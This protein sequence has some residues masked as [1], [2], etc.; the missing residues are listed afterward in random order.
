MKTLNL[1]GISLLIVLAVLFSGCSSI[2]EGVVNGS[3]SITGYVHGANVSS[4]K[5]EI[6]KDDDRQSWRTLGIFPLNSTTEDSVRGSILANWNTSQV[7]DGRYVV[8]VTAIDSNGLNSSDYVYLTV[9]NKAEKAACPV[10]TCSDLLEGDNK[11][12]VNLTKEQYGNNMNCTVRCSCGQ[13]LYALV[14]SNGNLEP[15]YYDYVDFGGIPKDS[16]GPNGGYN[17][18]YEYP[19]NWSARYPMGF[20]KDESIDIKLWTD[21]SNGGSAGYAGF[22]VSKI[23]CSPYCVSVP[24]ETKEYIAK[25]RLNNATSVTGNGTYS[26][27][28]ETSFSDLSAGQNYTL[29]VDVRSTAG[30]DLSGYVAAWID[31]DGNQDLATE[32]DNPDYDWDK[33][34][35]N[36][37]AT[38]PSPEYIDLG[39]QTLNK[40]VYTYS[41]TFSVPENASTGKARMRISLKEYDSTIGCLGTKES[42]AVYYNVISPESC[43][44]GMSG[45]VEDY[46]VNIK[47]GTCNLA[48]DEPPCGE[49]AVSEVVSLIGRWSAGDASLEDVLGLITAWSK[50]G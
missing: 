17:E 13:G 24:S 28:T 18:F 38:I 46:T 47:Q 7:S 23:I 10:W 29:E 16:E 8:R 1:A 2:N 15:G 45:E 27:Y 42:C 14:Y 3:V 50:Q 21:Y 22:D 41:K 9:E 36:M 35:P 6:S 19:D 40:G 25:V 4:Y 20:D 11:V 39:S 31:Y 48:G 5:I 37:S 33:M 34:D 44:A 26:D 30:Y 43:E 12:N 49:I 32:Q